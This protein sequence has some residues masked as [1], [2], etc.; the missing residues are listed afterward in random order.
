MFWWE[1]GRGYNRQ[2]GPAREPA[3]RRKGGQ[4][5]RENTGGWEGMLRGT[6]Q[7][8]EGEGGGRMPIRFGTYNI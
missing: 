4:S 6:G 7:A 8:V 3:G 2:G 1:R 5:G